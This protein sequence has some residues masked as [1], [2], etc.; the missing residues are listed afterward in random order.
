VGLHGQ[1]ATRKQI[2]FDPEDESNTFFRN[3]DKSQETVFFT[4]TAVRTSDPI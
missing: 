2:I 3:I 1:Q 4:A